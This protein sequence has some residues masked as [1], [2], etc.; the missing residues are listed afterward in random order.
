MDFATRDAYRHA[1]EELARGSGRSELEVAREAMARTHRGGRGRRRRRSDLA[2]ISSAR[3]PGLRAGRLATRAANAPAAAYL[4]RGGDARNI[5]D[6]RR[7]Q[8]LHVH[9]AP[10]GSRGSR[11]R[12]GEPCSCSPFW[13]SSRLRT[14][15]RSAESKRHRAGHAGRAAAARVA[16]RRAT[17]SANHGRRAEIC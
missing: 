6:D 14:G 5:W 1:V 8:W 4:R 16:R 11:R 9:A 7:P 3:A 15:D 10:P 17:G 13:P 12:I 2:S